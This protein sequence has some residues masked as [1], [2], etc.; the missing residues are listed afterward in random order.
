MEALSKEQ[1]NFL[2]LQSK[3]QIHA[4]QTDEEIKILE[5]SNEVNDIMSQAN[6]QNTA[7]IK[8]FD[9]KNNDIDIILASRLHQIGTYG[10]T[11]PFNWHEFGVSCGLCFNAPPICNF[12]NTPYMNQINNESQTCNPD[13][14]NS[15]IINIVSFP[16]S[17]QESSIIID[18][19]I[20]ID[21]IPLLS[22]NDLRYHLSRRG[23]LFQS[24]EFWSMEHLQQELVAKLNVNAPLVDNSRKVNFEMIEPDVFNA[25]DVNGLK[26][27]LKRRGILINSTLTQ[28]LRKK[29]RDALDKL[30]PIFEESY[31]ETEASST[32]QKQPSLSKSTIQIIE[33]TTTP[34]G[35][36]FV[37][38]TAGPSDDQIITSVESSIILQLPI[39]NDINELDE[40]QQIIDSAIEFDPQVYHEDK[41]HDVSETQK[42][43]EYQDKKENENQYEIENQSQDK[44]QDIQ[45]SET[46]TIV[47]DSLTVK[48]LKTYISEKNGIVGKK[49]KKELQE[50]LS[51]LV[52]GYSFEIPKVISLS[53][54]ETIIE[55]NRI[56]Q[57][58][59]ELELKKTRIITLYKN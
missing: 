14:I 18:E 38:Q 54:D 19:T 10:D 30:S 57:Q 31:T 2:N 12:F 52:N 8:K 26:Y 29:L 56:N 49:N 22:Q 55:L 48:M 47:I 44:N 33:P 53:T 23:I 13:N 42:E 25:L 40:Q 43:N 36:P 45:Y 3:Q 58:I 28:I 20:S 17:T 6:I 35:E 11:K 1:R 7:S 16:E 21:S 50:E 27:E 34:T 9:M 5:T 41:N 39:N 15:E 51:S 32:Q 46:E 37:E 4:K 59:K 24:T